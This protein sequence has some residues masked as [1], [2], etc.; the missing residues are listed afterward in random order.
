MTYAYQPRAGTLAFRALSWLRTF[1]E[2][3]ITAE[4]STSAWAGGLGVPGP[5]LIAAMQPAMRS[6]AVFC[7][8]KGGHIR[9]PLFW[10]LVDHSINGAAPKGIVMGP[11]IASEAAPPSSPDTPGR[12]SQPVVKA[13][14]AS[15]DATDRET[16]A[17]D[18][19]RVGAMGA[20]QPA[21]AGAAGDRIEVSPRLES[22][23]RPSVTV[24]PKGDGLTHVRINHA[25]G[26]RT[27]FDAHVGPVRDRTCDHGKSVYG[28]CE[29]CAAD[30]SAGGTDGLLV[31]GAAPAAREVPAVALVTLSFTVSLHLSE[32]ITQAVAKITEVRS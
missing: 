29:Q 13:E 1:V 22:V 27:E 10:S 3:D 16:P 17:N 31:G 14:G 18:R 26:A 6:R 32:R 19:P 25:G 28:R 2:D 21:D 20:G 7:R 11:A 23:W 9:S 4:L 30:I 5:D 8:Q 24:T 12:D 15:P